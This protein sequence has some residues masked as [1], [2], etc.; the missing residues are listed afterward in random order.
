MK[1][2]FLIIFLGVAMH[3]AL[4]KATH[5]RGGEIQYKRIQPFTEIVGG[6]TVQVFH[7]AITIIKYMNHGDIIADRC[8]DTVHFGDGTIGVARRI[9]GPTSCCSAIGG[10]TVGCG[11]VIVNDQFYVVKLSIYYITHVYKAPGNYIVATRDVNRNAGIVNIPNSDATPLCIS[12]EIQINSLAGMNS[13]PV[14]THLPVDQG[15][16]NACFLHN[17]AAIDA[18]GDSLSYEL[19]NCLC[20]AGYNHPDAG[21]GGSF[22]IHPT[23]GILTWCNPK[24]MGEYNF[25]IKIREW[26][27]NSSGLPINIGFVIR[28]MQVLVNRVYTGLDSEDN[29]QDIQ[30]FPNPINGQLIVKPGNTNMSELRMYNMAG[31]LVLIKNSGFGTEISLQLESL[32]KGIYTLELRVSGG[33]IVKKVV[34]D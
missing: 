28:E 6:N 33:T 13:S 22:T 11:E 14:L 17:P 20:A 10:S 1:K 25:S 26:R 5:N 3:S 16:L 30:I 27:K 29:E 24:Q 19:I 7:Y 32:P 21:S 18:D 4:L 12:A 34:K 8:V 9:N 15:S 31:Q 2:L 23:T